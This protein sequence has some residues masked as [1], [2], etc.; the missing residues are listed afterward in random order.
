MICLCLFINRLQY[1]SPRSIGVSLSSAGF[2]SAPGS[3]CWPSF[4]VLSDSPAVDT[5][6]VPEEWSAVDTA[7]VPKEGLAVDTAAVP[8]EWSSVMLSV[9]D[10]DACFTDDRIFARFSMMAFAMSIKELAR[11]RPMVALIGQRILASCRII[12]T[13]KGSMA[14]IGDTVPW[15]TVGSIWFLLH[16]LRMAA[17]LIVKSATLCDAVASVMIIARVP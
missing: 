13:K 4:F 15:D 17:G 9:D 5:A 11:W 6:A 8:K 2:S 14:A 16:R 12:A 10:G 3:L 1:P 7:A